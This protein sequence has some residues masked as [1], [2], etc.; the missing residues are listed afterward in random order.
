MD[1]SK[2][3]KSFDNRCAALVSRERRAPRARRDRKSCIDN[4]LRLMS[5]LSRA[6]G[7]QV[8]R[9]ARGSNGGRDC[10]TTF[11]R[12]A[13]SELVEPACRALST[14]RG[15]AGATPSK[16]GNVTPSHT[17]VTE[18]HTCDIAC[19]IHKPMRWNGLDLELQ[20]KDTH[21]REMCD[22]LR[23]FGTWA[24][25]HRRSH[26]QDGCATSCNILENAKNVAF[27]CILLYRHAR[28]NLVFPSWRGRS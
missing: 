11:S 17:N 10:T 13:C 7:A 27:R 9:A 2:F 23:H 19:S 25:P 14:L 3:E 1:E 21:F 26:S 20:P 5:P 28:V 24:P 4:R 16:N 8:S 12:P 18:C 15:V 22:I 6:R